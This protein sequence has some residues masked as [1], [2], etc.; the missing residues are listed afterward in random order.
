MV[1]RRG[2]I[3]WEMVVLT[4]KTH[5]PNPC[6]RRETAKARDKEEKKRPTPP[7]GHHCSIR[8]K[9][10]RIVQR[11]TTEKRIGD[12]ATKKEKKPWQTAPWPPRKRSSRPTSIR[13]ERDA[14][15][16]KRGEPRLRRG[17]TAERANASG[18][19]TRSSKVA[20]GCRGAV[21]ILVRVRR[22]QLR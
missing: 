18:E 15:R 6:P 1:S 22:R 5:A 9:K 11:K 20:A 12:Q 14:D 7:N 3:C 21:W 2:G 13:K 8:K 17:K 4:A 16:L 19:P 10:K